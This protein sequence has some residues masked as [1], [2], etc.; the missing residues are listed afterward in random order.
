MTWR[1]MT[2]PSLETAP[3]GLA[4]G[5]VVAAGRHAVDSRFTAPRPSACSR[6]VGAQPGERSEPRHTRGALSQHPSLVNPVAVLRLGDVFGSARCAAQRRGSAAADLAAGR[7]R[8]DVSMMP[9]TTGRTL[10]ASP[11]LSLVL[12]ANSR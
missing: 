1:L 6:L 7:R 2:A 9:A 4:L 11:S 12:Q 3:C 8:P 5:T 10:T